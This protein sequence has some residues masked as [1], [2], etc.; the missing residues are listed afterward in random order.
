[1]NSLKTLMGVSTLV[2]GAAAA[3]ASITS[4]AGTTTWLGSPP[5]SAA[6]GFLMGPTTYAWDERQNVSTTGV[7]CDMLNNPGNSS[8]PVPGTIA[9][10]FDSH[11]LHF[12]LPFGGGVGGSVTF[13]GQIIG[14]MFVGLSLDNTDAL[15]GSFGTVYPTGDPGRGL[16]PFSSF[17]I[18]A[19]VLTYQFATIA[20]SKD[21]IEV[22][23]LT[24]PVPTPG[25]MALLGLGGIVSVRRRRSAARF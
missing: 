5:P 22:R 3:S 19:N 25:A 2:L 15:F 12:Q 17:S 13:S 7:F 18:N 16:N 24:H 14:V 1:M 21:I 11:M 4:V 23:V 9:G 6:T 8:S 20:P 10:A